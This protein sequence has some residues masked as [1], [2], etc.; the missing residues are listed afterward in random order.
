[1]NPWGRRL[2]RSATIEGRPR[3]RLFF[4]QSGERLLQAAE[5]EGDR[6]V[7]ACRILECDT[8]RLFAVIDHCDHFSGGG[9]ARETA[10]RDT[11]LP[12]EFERMRIALLAE[13]F[14]LNDIYGENKRGTQ[15]WIF[16]SRRIN[17]VSA[18]GVPHASRINRLDCQTS[19]FSCIGRKGVFPV[20]SN[21]QGQELVVRFGAGQRRHSGLITGTLSETPALARWSSRFLMHE[22]GQIRRRLFGL[23]QTSRR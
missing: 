6:D 18:L 3:S 19:L 16:G 9:R 12:C 8:S 23:A 17:L 11:A 7:F 13:K 20:V 15:H 1:M 5:G 2:N 14:R 10:S 22:I 21:L 4:V